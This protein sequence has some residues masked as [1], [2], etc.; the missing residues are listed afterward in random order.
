MP[1]SVVLVLIREQPSGALFR[2]YGVLPDDNTHGVSKYHLLIFAGGRVAPMSVV[3]AVSGR[4]NPTVSDQGSTTAALVG[5]IR[6]MMA[7]DDNP[8]PL[9]WLR[10][11]I[12]TSSLDQVDSHLI[13][14]THTSNR[15][16]ETDIG[17][18]G[19]NNIFKICQP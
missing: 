5:S 18:I 12:K 7:V 9:P 10:Q 14:L 8:G 4:D 11:T 1:F 3:E 15:Q 6:D 13:C 2:P 19:D 16:V 17:H